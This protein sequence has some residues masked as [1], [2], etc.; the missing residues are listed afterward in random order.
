[1]ISSQERGEGQVVQGA[2]DHDTKLEL[3]S[4]LSRRPLR[5]CEQQ[6]NM[7]QFTFKKIITAM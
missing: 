5:G 6:G 1:M 3:H 7:I 4:N 2:V